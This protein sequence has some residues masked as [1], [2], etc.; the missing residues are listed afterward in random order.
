MLDAAHRGESRVAVITGEP[1]IGKTA[2]LRYAQ[3]RAS[4]MLVLRA[5]G[6][7][8]E[9]ELESSALDDLFRSLPEATKPP[10]IRTGGLRVHDRLSRGVATL[11]ILSR[12]AEERPI[13]L[14]LDDI[15]WVDQSSLDAV[16]FAARRFSADRI[17]VLL[18]ARDGFVSADLLRSFRRIGL[19]G[20]IGPDA[21]TL[22]RRS[23]GGP[24]AEQVAVKLHGAT[25][26]NPLAL[27]EIS[28]VLAG[29]Q[30]A[31]LAPIEEPL[32]VGTAVEQAFARRL[33]R[34]PEGDRRA[35]VI[36][37]VSS[38]EA[39]D[40]IASA[41]RAADM[42]I[43]ALERSE[44]E[45][46]ISIADGRVLFDHPLIRS[47]VHQMA[48][49][50]A[51]RAAH[52]AV[53]QALAEGNSERHAWHMAAA[54][55][56]PSE[57]VAAAL[58]AA[59]RVARDRGGYVT[60]AVALERAASLT[61]EPA[62]RGRRR[63]LAAR[64][65][66]DAGRTDRALELLGDALTLPADR[67]L[68]AEMLYL[69]GHIQ[70]LTG[71]V[72]NAFESL[73]EAAT[74]IEEEDPARAAEFLHDAAESHGYAFQPHSML[75]AARRAYELAPSGTGGKFLAEIR[76]GEAL[77]YL[78]RWA[79]AVGCFEQAVAALPTATDQQWPPFLQ[80]N[81]ALGLSWL[82]RRAEAVTLAERAVADARAHSALTTL[83]YA[84]EIEAW[85]RLRSGQWHG[86][87]ALATEVVLL[88]RE[89]GQSTQLALALAELSTIDAVRGDTASCRANLAE[90]FV[91]S[92]RKQ[93]R[94]VARW[95]RRSEALLELGL[96]QVAKAITLLEEIDR[97]FGETDAFGE[98]GCPV[99]DLVEAY[100]RAGR[101]DDA[102]LL[103]ERFQRVGAR[104]YGIYGAA[105]AARYEGLLA[106]EDGYRA[107][108]EQ[109]QTLH[110]RLGDPFA[111]ARTSLLFG[112]RL[113]RSGHR[114]EARTQLR[115]ALDTF[116]ALGADPWSARCRSELRATGIT[117]RRH[118]SLAAELTPQELQVALKVV[119]GQ[120]NREVAAALFLSPKTVE[121]HLG[122]VFRKLGIRSRTQLARLFAEEARA[123]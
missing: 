79:E 75:T 32:T 94:Y 14:T 65:A 77:L 108:F 43:S 103:L 100:H 80:S 50:S 84:L 26:G 59:A 1:G 97:E 48:R 120:T 121:F 81:A 21:A 78:G 107:H 57:E 95:A 123:S 55:I 12:V 36:V 3:D 72:R 92:G 35:L 105:H 27:T 16:L 70:H 64:A 38:S 101:C 39:I 110:E 117:V 52:R 47:V 113:R 23:A 69:R 34:L 102:R 46:L 67:R 5:T 40:V 86:C 28:R 119:T 51:R 25:R 122:G 83:V 88:A 13:L 85:T 74:L 49:P 54:T 115:S 99:P 63:Y 19:D 98:E 62:E 33:V 61:P 82:D 6:I 76:M 58:E 42:D 90:A 22:L 73:V 20:L 4:G 114:A 44:D 118:D 116:D 111:A 18:A 91:L 56:T 11:D 41:L 109:A 30:L 7:E 93:L 71:P 17:A 60:G 9:A 66:W 89:T 112:E 96:G 31:G 45:G 53:A 29:D 68:R 15:Q 104:E 8:S 24:I 87:Y 10:E 37:A 2:L 106:A